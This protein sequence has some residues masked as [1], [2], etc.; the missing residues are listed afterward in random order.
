[1]VILSKDKFSLTR[2]PLYLMNE[3][4]LSKWPVAP[5]ILLTFAE[6]WT[7]C[8]SD[9]FLKYA[10]HLFP[11][12]VGRSCSALA[13][14]QHVFLLQQKVEGVLV[15]LRRSAEARNGVTCSEALSGSSSSSD[16]GSPLASFYLIIISFIKRPEYKSDPLSSC[17]NHSASFRCWSLSHDVIV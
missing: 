8:S 6:W 15:C 9:S 4:F 7:G 13:S 5:G 14:S 3:G 1:M 11:K 2:R 17:A 10:Q 12:L 16:T